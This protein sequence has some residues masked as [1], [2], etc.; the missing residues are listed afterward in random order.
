[1]TQE[2][3]SNTKPR[4]R[5]F[6][7]SLASLLV[8]LTVVCVGLG[9][10]VN[11]V[12]RH[13]RAIETIQKWVEMMDTEFGSHERN[14][15]FT[16]FIIYSHEWNQNTKTFSPNATT[17]IGN[18]F[19]RLLGEDTAIDVD[20]L[21][22]IDS[23]GNGFSCD[24]DDLKH[25][26]AMHQLRRLNLNC[27]EITDAGLRDIRGLTQLT[28]LR[29]ANNKKITDAGIANL[30]SLHKLKKL[31]LFRISGV[32]AAGRKELQLALPNCRIL[33]SLPGELPPS[34]HQVKL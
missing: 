18:W 2:A 21:L 19:Q 7:F 17:P 9:V 3:E 23:F 14:A 15:S 31:R 13:N 24:D 22:L 4:R 32:T 1:M 5:W 20:S 11:R 29:I 10:Y 25:V 12:R 6:Q 34:K 27:R 28:Q 8:L 16:P 33:Y 26:A 30:A